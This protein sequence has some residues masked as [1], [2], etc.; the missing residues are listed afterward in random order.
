MAALVAI[1]LVLLVGAGGTALYLTHKSAPKHASSDDSLN[2]ERSTASP[3]SSSS[4][5]AASTGKEMPKGERLT[6]AMAME[7]VKAALDEAGKPTPDCSKVLHELDVN[8]G[9]SRASATSSNES[10]FEKAGR[11][12]EREGRWGI[13]RGV[14]TAIAAGDSHSKVAPIFRGRALTGLGHYKEAFTIAKDLLKSNP[15]DANAASMYATA[16]CH[17]AAEGGAHTQELYDDCARDAAIGNKSNEEGAKDPDVAFETAIN[18]SDAFFHQGKFDDS[19]KALADAAQLRPDDGRIKKWQKRIS[20][21]KADKVGVDKQ[22]QNNVFLGL[23]H[24]YGKDIGKYP[25]MP[26]VATFLVYNFSGQDLPISVEV[27][28]PGVTE[29]SKKTDVV[30]AGKFTK[31]ALTPSLK[32]DYNLAG[33]RAEQPAKLVFKIA[34]QDGSK[35]FYEDEKDIKIHPR[36]ELPLRITMNDTDELLTFHFGAAW[37]TPNAKAVDGFLQKAKTHAP[38]NRFA[39]DQTESVPQVGAIF[40][41]LHSEGMSYVM[42]PRLSSSYGLVQRVRLPTEV[43]E[44]K[45]AQC[46]EGQLTYSTL[47]E[48]IGLRAV[49]FYVQGH[50]FGGWVAND[51]DKKHPEWMKYA[52]KLPSG[53]D[54][55]ILET[56]VTDEAKTIDEVLATGKHTYKEHIVDGKELETGQANYYF[57]SEERS[58]GI[59]PQPIE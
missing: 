14:A 11:C 25:A 43:L 49:Q 22:V 51:Y 53:E 29:H 19:S 30:L 15:K 13:L 52:V 12:A 31:V 46:V 48:S 33:I 16:E 5:T 42:D 27:E 37:V 56:T 45:N 55:F 35:T 23:Y 32:A 57:L 3:K 58:A 26:A 44:S 59:T 50:S 10:A 39:G 38:N 47:L 2:S 36:D 1:P 28:I 21:V 54:V 41:E 18:A 17:V 24:L 9:V 34:A 7:H 4:A 20:I 40:E 6:P 8:L